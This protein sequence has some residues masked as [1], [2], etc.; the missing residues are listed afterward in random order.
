M[1][2]FR[3]V[4]TLCAL[5]SLRGWKH[6]LS[7]ASDR[8]SRL[9]IVTYGEVIFEFDEFAAAAESGRLYGRQ[10]FDLVAPRDCLARLHL[11]RSRHYL[12]Y[13]RRSTHLLVRVKRRVLSHT[14]STKHGHREIVG[15][16]HHILVVRR[17]FLWISGLYIRFLTPLTFL[18]AFWL[19]YSLFF[20]L[21]LL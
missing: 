5:R 10:V 9:Q 18:L 17:L 21:C 15:N 4:L 13:H 14:H 16:F 6:R 1:T 12:Q 8:S 20:C 3:Y 11:L 2:S 19:F 7:C